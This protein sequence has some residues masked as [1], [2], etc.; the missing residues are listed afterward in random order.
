MKKQHPNKV[1]VA[2]VYWIKCELG[3]LSAMFWLW[4]KSD[5]NFNYY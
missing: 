3:S 5:S 4:R 1:D 2:A